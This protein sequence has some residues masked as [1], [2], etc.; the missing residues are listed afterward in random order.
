MC[1]TGVGGTEAKKPFQMFCLAD[2]WGRIHGELA[3]Y[4]WPLILFMF[5][6]ETPPP[7]VHRLASLNHSLEA[8]VPRAED[9]DAHVLCIL[10]TSPHTQKQGKDLLVLFLLRLPGTIIAHPWWENNILSFSLMR[11]IGGLESWK[12]YKQA[13]LVSAMGQIGW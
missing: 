4:P 12:P 5:T 6:E 13:H 9:Q 7:T 2:D 8:S 3:T 11:L 1:T 10:E